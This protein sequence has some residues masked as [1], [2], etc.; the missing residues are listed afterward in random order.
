MSYEPVFRNKLL[1]LL[2]QAERTAILRHL[3][4]V[5]L[6][7]GFCLAGVQD[8]ITHVYFLEDGIGSIVAVSPEGQK[9]EAGMVGSEG[10]V[11]L[12]AVVH[13]KISLHEVVMQAS[14]S[15]HRIGI[16]AFWELMD[17]CP[18]LVSLMTRASHNLATQVSFTALSNAVHQ[19]DER[20]ARWLLMY[21]DRLATDELNITHEYISLMLAVRRPSVTTALHILEGNQFIRSERGVITIRNRRALEDFARDAYGRPEQ[22]YRLLFGRT[23]AARQQ[24]AV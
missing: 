9:A 12:P 11:P 24:L 8:E 17:M 3:E 22:E 5:P 21:H 18:T 7:K 23:D 1:A 13:S 2:P 19:I 14:G 10:F 6:G 20:L 15:G 16:D 4:N